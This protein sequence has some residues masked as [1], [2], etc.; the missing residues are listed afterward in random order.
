MDDA[1]GPILLFDGLCPFCHWAVRVVIA[2]DRRGTMRF[3]PLE[4]ETASAILARHPALRGVDSLVL[5][6]T[7]AGGE[8]VWTRA[9]A[10]LRL[11]AYLGG[12]W[13][14]CAVLRLVPPFLSDGAYDLFARL[15]AAV[16]GRYPACPAPRPGVRARFLP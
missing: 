10:V 9:E 15:R 8:R 13:R 1:G 2:A 11:A 3:A 6:G 4:G 16:F 12:A 5:V 14:A 7:G